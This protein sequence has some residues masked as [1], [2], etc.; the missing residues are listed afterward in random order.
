MKIFSPVPINTSSISGFIEWHELTFR[1]R[2]LDRS[3]T[4]SG[5][6]AQTS[7]YNASATLLLITGAEGNFGAIEDSDP[8]ISV[9]TQ[10]DDWVV[11]TIDLS[12]FTDNITSLRFDPNSGTPSGFEVDYITLTANAVPEPATVA[13]GLGVA[14]LGFTLWRRRRRS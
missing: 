12:G 5:P 11:A 7:T 13:L 3:P 1:F 4:S 8:R 10:A 14:A 6:S 2:Q 9:T